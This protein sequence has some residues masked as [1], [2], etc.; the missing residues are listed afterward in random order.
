MGTDLRLYTFLI[1][2][3]KFGLL[4]VSLHDLTK[5]LLVTVRRGGEGFDR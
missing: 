1:T 4:L 5:V 2:K 3:S